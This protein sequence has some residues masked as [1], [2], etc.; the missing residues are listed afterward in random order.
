MNRP[1]RNG[2]PDAAAEPD[3]TAEPGLARLVCVL[4][5][6]SRVGPVQAR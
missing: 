5:A 6:W 1:G 3:R 2:A 4:S